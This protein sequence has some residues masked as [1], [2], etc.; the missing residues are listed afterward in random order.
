MTDIWAACAAHITPSKLNGE[1]LRI[2]ESQEQVATNQIV[3]NFEEQG[4][5]ELLLEQTKPPR[6][7]GTEGLHYLLATPFRYPPLIHG[8]RFGSRFSP[9]LF[10][11]SH[12]LATALAESGYYRFLFWF[13]M[14][15]PPASGRFITQHTVFAASYKTQ[16]GL[17]LQDVPFS[18]YESQLTDPEHYTATQALGASMRDNGIEAFEYVAARD[19]EHGINV[20]LFIPQ[21]LSR[22]QPLYQQQWLCETNANYVSFYTS[23]DGNLHQFRLDAYLVKGKFPQAAA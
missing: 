8:S 14:S 21:V 2:V 11:G 4:V 10:Y 22:Q 17:K 5:L 12:S 16:S 18:K 15:S 13:G 3:D 1:L 6:P 20:A 7:P 19:R 23:A 9:S